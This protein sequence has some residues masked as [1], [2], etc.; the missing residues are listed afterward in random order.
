M[1]APALLRLSDHALF[2]VLALLVPVRA[3]LVGMRS[4]KRAAAADVPAI[5]MRYYHR[6]MAMQWTLAAL[7]ALNWAWA[8]RPWSLLGVVP[9]LNGG[10]IGVGVGILVVAGLLI[11]QGRLA[12]NDEAALAELRARNRHL[13]RV[14]PATRRERNWFFALAVTAGICEEV[15]Y[16]GYVI[17]YLAAWAWLVDPAHAFLLA[18]GGSSIVFG[19]GH[20]YQG[21]RGA[22]LTG[23][24]GAFLAAI[25]WIT[26][27]LLAGV[28][29]HAMMDVH[30][31]YLSYLAYRRS[32]S[33]QPAAARE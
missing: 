10:L 4:L 13:E 31:G 14:L 19:L 21:P 2:V 12:P 1:T 33:D 16:R 29:I 28:L 5:K 7:V 24:V 17:W 23:F 22:A 20:L 9:G 25:Y 26:R 18:A 6:A 8:R 11:Y 3:G 27:S 30:A 32:G 15:L